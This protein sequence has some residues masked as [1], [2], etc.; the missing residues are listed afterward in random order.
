MKKQKQTIAKNKKEKAEW[1]N[2]RDVTF[3]TKDYHFNLPEV[4][5]LQST[6]CWN[7]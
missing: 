2:K 4:G 3:D 5:K 7:K 6:I 1:T